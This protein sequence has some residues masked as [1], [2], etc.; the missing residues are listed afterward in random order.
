MKFRKKYTPKEAKEQIEIIQCQL[1][2]NF[3]E[4]WYWTHKDDPLILA[5]VKMTKEECIAQA[6]KQNEYLSQKMDYLRKFL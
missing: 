6:F 2:N 5:M 1:R 4:I 3:E